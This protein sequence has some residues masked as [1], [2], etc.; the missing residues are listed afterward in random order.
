MS[1]KCG[2]VW[3]TRKA[4]KFAWETSQDI[5]TWKIKKE[6]TALRWILGR[7]YNKGKWVE[8]AQSNVQF[9]ALVFVLLNLLVLLLE[10]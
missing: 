3:Q 7:S 9:W 2:Q 4:Y 5:A 10:C 8:R 1:W 6:K